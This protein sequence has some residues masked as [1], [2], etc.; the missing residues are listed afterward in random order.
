MGFRRGEGNEKLLTCVSCENPMALDAEYCSECGAKRAVATGYEKIE[1]D[2]VETDIGQKSLKSE[3]RVINSKLSKFRTK[4]DSGFLRFNKVLIKNKRSILFSTTA[5][6]VIV[7][8]VMVQTIIFSSQSTEKI[9]KA[10]IEF[11][12]SRDVKAI[13]ANPQLF[14][15][16]KN[17]P[18]LPPQYQTQSRWNGWLGEANINFVP[19]INGELNYSKQ[20]SMKLKANYRT[21]ALLFREIEWEVSTP[22]ASIKPD[23][24]VDLN[25]STF[26]NNVEVG[27]SDS[28]PLNSSEYA[29]LPGPYIF[30]ATGEGFTKQR[31]NTFF[32][33]STG[34]NIS[35]FEELSFD[36]NSSQKNSA[37]NQ[38]EQVLTNCLK[39][40]CSDLPLLSQW[41]F[42]FSNQPATYL[43]TDYFKYSWGSDAQCE[44]AE[45]LTYSKD[46]A[47]ITM[48]CTATA[49]SSVKWIL[50]RIFLTTY[51]DLGYDYGTFDLTIT[52]DLEPLSSS[53]S[54]KV[55][56]I[57]IN[58]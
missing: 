22:I 21:K 27:K 9:S 4:L 31:I 18:I 32:V 56:N 38:V 3:S 14:P 29:L 35:N 54:V 39:K 10:Y 44:P 6:L 42:D 11:V 43:Y 36:L 58:Y 7:T 53:D 45:Y 46:S 26:L 23:Q 52:G 24:D 28:Q 55:S 19:E 37:E 33:N 13:D 2:L 5:M 8:Y 40:K 12:S 16:P 25:Q 51:Y 49:S 41:D 30:V 1:N 50:Y 57:K 34:E 15:N 20:I 47:S 17:L 48:K